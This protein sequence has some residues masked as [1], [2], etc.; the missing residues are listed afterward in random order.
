[1]GTPVP[2]CRWLLGPLLLLGLFAAAGGAPA[3][4]GSV[5]IKGSDTMVVLTQKWAE[6]YMALHPEATIQVNGGGTGT[7]FAALQARATDICN[8]SRRIRAKEK[9]NCLRAF[10]KLPTEYPVALD[11]L[12]IYVHQGNPLK[13]MDLETLAGIYTGAITNWSA[14]GGPRAPITVYSRENSSG[15][16]EFFKERVLLGRDFSARVQTLQGT[17]QVLEAVARDPF[18]IGYGGAAYGQGARHLKVS[19][20]ADSEAIGPSEATVTSGAYPISR[21]L[22]CYVNPDLDRGDVAGYLRWIRSREGQAIV[23]D[24]GYYP[25][26]PEARTD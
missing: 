15:T 13:Q 1:M 20:T 26:P 16:Y 17:A 22:Y 11:G 18:G 7:G 10:R 25:L 2:I 21:F 3:R 12:H 24:L 8:A 9:E 4:A 6:T 19:R 5:T 14:L 23:R